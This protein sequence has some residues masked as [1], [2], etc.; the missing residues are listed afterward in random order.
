MREGRLVAVDT[1]A[2]LCAAAGKPRLEDAVVALLEEE[3][4]A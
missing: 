4:A 2:A 3:A 1:P